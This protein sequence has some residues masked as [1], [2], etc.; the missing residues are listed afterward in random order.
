ML[1]RLCPILVMASALA[2]A[3]VTI[4]EINPTHSDLGGNGATGGRVQH[5]ARATDSIYYAASE[6]GGLFKSTNG[7]RAWTR[8]DAYLP[9]RTS[10]IEVS[11]VDP[12]RVIATSL[13]DG[14]VNSVAGIGVSTDG[15]ATWTK[16]PTATPPQNFCA[17][18]TIAEPAAF[19]ISFNPDT[20]NQVFVGTNCGL[21]VS[22]DSGTTW[23]FVDPTPAN[24][25]GRIFDVIVHDGGIIDTCGSDGHRRSV[26]G[27]G[28]PWTSTTG[29][30]QPLPAANCSLAVSPDE[31]YVLFATAG[32]LIFETDNGGGSWNTE[33][34]NPARQGRVPYVAVNDR[35]GRNFDL[36]F[37]DVRVFRAG[38]TTPTAPAVGGVARCPA[39]TVWVNVTDDAHADQGDVAFAAPATGSLAACRASCTATQTACNQDCVEIRDECIA[40]RGP[41]APTIAQCNQ[42]FTQCRNQC[43]SALNTCNTRCVQGQERCPAVLS[44]DG[45]TYFNA[46][47]QSPACQTPDWTQPD[48]TTRALWLW[49]LSG[50]NIGG[51]LAQ[52]AVYMGAQ[53]NGTFAST[54]AGSGAPLWNNRDCCD[55]FDT[56]AAEGQVLYTV[57]CF[58]PPPGNRLFVRNQGMTGGGEVPNY[59]P[60]TGVIPGFGFP[61]VV[62]RFGTN[63]YALVN[64]AGIFV[65]LNVTANPIAWTRLGAN[66]PLNA[67]AIHAAGT[68]QNP[69]FYAQTVNCSGNG[70]GPVVR[71]AGTGSTGNWQPVNG[72]AGIGLFSVDRSNPAR[73]IISAFDLNGPHMFRSNDSGAMWTPISNLDP[74]MTGNGTFRLAPIGY[75]QPT[76]AAFD[77]ANANTILAGAADAGLFLSQNNGTSW[78]T[79]T[80]NSGGAANP[81]IP[82]PYWSYFDRECGSTSIFV[83]TQG[84]GAWRFRFP[85]PNAPTVAQCQSNCEAARQPCLNDCTA[86]RDQCMSEVGTPGGPLASQCVQRFIQC[87][88]QCTSQVNA[89]R[90]RCVEC[91]Q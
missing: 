37:G 90:Q 3:Q 55:G 34:V 27:S 81:V 45:G 7:G 40:E 66:P 76:M 28:G 83:G 70:I 78:T 82:R 2:E 72:P 88:N 11:P 79:V 25:A 44:C 59:P 12:N 46:R 61:D 52:E 73:L 6:F 53:D 30:G 4:A 77:P 80:N 29:G 20:P 38:C 33:F 67:C 50:S 89:C 36:W 32:T 35:A 18:Q 71:L 69:V 68:Q 13:F 5:V 21:A 56:V 60:G 31:P 63:R 17:A 14:R 23:T 86:D 54:N 43:A 91:P 9:T 10:D 57:C 42:R 19:G 41:G 62:A 8:L 74:L 85:D 49:S 1:S 15:G 26:S 48:V 65:T 16:P 47:T 84:R 22:N 24:A 39:S 87:R 58:S 51:S 64:T 75:V